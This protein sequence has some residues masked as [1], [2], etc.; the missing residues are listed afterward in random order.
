MTND[1]IWTSQYAKVPWRP[2]FRP[3]EQC[4]AAPPARE[5][6]I[7]AS[8]NSSITATSMPVTSAVRSAG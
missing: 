7:H 1:N 5:A 6:E 3:V 4:T 8:A 2:M